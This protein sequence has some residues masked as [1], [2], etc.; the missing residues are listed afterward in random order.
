M[1]GACT[2]EDEN[3][4]QVTLA[5]DQPTSITVPANQNSEQIRF[6]ATSA[7]SAW[8][9]TES[10]GVNDVEWIHLDNASGSAGDVY[11]NFTLDYNNTGE[12]RTAYMIIVCGDTRIVVTITQTSDDDPDVANPITEGLVEVE[13]K[14]FDENSGQGYTFDGTTNYVITYSN[15]LPVRMVSKWRD[16][17]AVGPDAPAD[18]D[19]YCL[20]E[21][22]TRFNWDG[23][24]RIDVSSVNVDSQISV[25]YY[26]SE[27]KEI[28]DP[29][30][31]FAEIEGSGVVGGWYWWPREDSNKSEWTAAYDKGYLISSRNNDA[32]PVW[33][34]H[35]MTWED[36]DL[37]K[38][39]SDSED[40][41][42][43][44]IT[45][46]DPSLLNLHREFD[47]NWVLPKELECYDFAAG[48][49]TKIFPSIGFMG[50]P[51]R[52]LITA[53][54]E[55]DGG[56]TTHSYRMNYTVNTRE[57]TVVTV[58][59]FVNDVQKSY[60]EWTIRYTNIR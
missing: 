26:P 32:S 41:R 11:L 9:S 56:N 54:T 60:S 15:G 47:I 1:L 23:N 48:D 5:E 13:V 37:T 34:T 51:S 38:I 58:M 35:T 40:G 49:I 8:T 28:E 57:K 46:A 31:H 39:V 59:Y 7:W 53:I 19:S 36:G 30:E 10:R 45:Y 43:I 33:E 52:H 21:E 4:Y 24:N 42:Y 22:T 25:T 2:S 55:Y 12:S 20:N 17:M 6:T 50:K 29:S 16:D 18:H 27:R 14:S 3:L 44:T